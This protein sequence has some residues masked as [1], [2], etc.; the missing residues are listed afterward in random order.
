M[1]RLSRR[2]GFTLIELLVVIAIIAVL[3]GLLLP[4]VQKVREAS[5]KSTCG[6]NLHQLVIAANGY[7]AAQDK[8]PP[9]MDIQH[10][11]CL[12][13]LLPHMEQDPRFKNW[14]FNSAYTFYYQDP[15]NRPPSTGTDTIPVRPDGKPQYGTQGTIKSFLCPS[16]PLPD[17]STTAMISVNYGDV[18]INYTAGAP[19]GHVFSSA[20]GRL[21]VGRSNYLG[22]AGECRNFAPYNSYKGLFTYKNPASLARIPDGNST[23]LLFAE[24]VGGW[25]NWNG[26]GGIPNGLGMPGW[27]CGFNYSCFGLDTNISLNDG[28][29]G[30]WS[31]G[32]MHIN[33]LIQVAYADGSVRQLSPTTSFAVFLALSGYNDNQVVTID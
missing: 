4:A 19:G 18:G 8:L 10:V 28:G 16:A 21:V 20:P 15:N 11:G 5:A 6:N 32:S 31:F 24:Q 17:E 25:I 12:V 1:S 22:V 13:Y 29:H 26:S 3:I 2:P 23:T 14:S 27:P 33:G 7:Q 30:W 9:G